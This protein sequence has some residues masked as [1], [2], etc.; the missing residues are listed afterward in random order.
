MSALYRRREYRDR[1]IGLFDFELEKAPKRPSGAG[2]GRKI[3]PLTA[4]KWTGPR[5]QGGPH[6]VPTPDR[7]S[8][9]MFIKVMSPDRVLDRQTRQQR[10]DVKGEPQSHGGAQAGQRVRCLLRQRR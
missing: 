6:E 1:G 2:S 5:V 8:G 9:L 7:L 3:V 10:A 4:R